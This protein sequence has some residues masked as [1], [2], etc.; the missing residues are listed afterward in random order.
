[1]TKWSIQPNIDKVNCDHR[2]VILSCFFSASIEKWPYK[3][4]CFT[5]KIYKENSC[6]HPSLFSNMLKCLFVFTT[7]QLKSYIDYEIFII[8]SVWWLP[9]EWE[10]GSTVGWV[11]S[12]SEPWWPERDKL[13]GILHGHRELFALQS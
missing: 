9:C 10:G 13:T 2:N 1:M 7:L 3:Q 12:S 11:A 4:A 8:V 5:C 6:I